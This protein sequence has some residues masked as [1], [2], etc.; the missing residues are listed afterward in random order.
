MQNVS[1]KSGSKW[2]AIG[3]FQ[4]WA[5]ITPLTIAHKEY[6]QLLN[7]INIYQHVLPTYFAANKEYFT[8]L[9]T[10]LIHIDIICIFAP[11]IFI[12][13]VNNYLKAYLKICIIYLWKSQFGNH[14]DLHWGHHSIANAVMIVRGIPVSSRY[15]AQVVNYHSSKLCMLLSNKKKCVNI[16]WF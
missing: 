6:Y 3:W 4:I 15:L 13:L 11:F 1:R 10:W 8:S 5:L 9:N 2:S 7:I 12:H 14:T 16:I